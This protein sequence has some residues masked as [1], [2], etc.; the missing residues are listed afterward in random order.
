MFKLPYTASVVYLLTTLPTARP[1]DQSLA[2]SYFCKIT[3][4][5]VTHQWPI[6]LFHTG[7]YNSDDNQSEFLDDA[8][9]ANDVTV[10]D[11]ERLLERI[12]FIHLRH[13]LPS[14]IPSTP[15]S[16][17][18]FLPTGGQATTCARSFLTRYSSIRASVLRP[19]RRRFLHPRARLLRPSRLY[20]RS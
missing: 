11:T 16:T 12:E 3:F 17:S 14:D 10:E 6:L 19:P 5:D 8:A 15:K 18:R 9:A 7:I 20:A 13:G 4:R 1:K 2:R